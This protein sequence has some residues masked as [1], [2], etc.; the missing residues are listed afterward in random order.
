MECLLHEVFQFLLDM[1]A[2]YVMLYLFI[3]R[4]DNVG[5]ELL[6]NALYSIKLLEVLKRHLDI[7]QYSFFQLFFCFSL[8]T[9]CRQTSCDSC[10][11]RQDNG[12]I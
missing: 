10:I 2:G 11:L 9:I 6:V 12:I 5:P 3:A 4:P 7:G 1:D 8:V